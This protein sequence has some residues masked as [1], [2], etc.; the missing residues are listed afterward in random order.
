[1]YMLPLALGTAVGVLV[2]QAI[3]ARDFV[4]A[5]STVIMGIALALLLALASERW[6]S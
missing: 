2:G 1:M 3:G 6:C 4:R 5:R